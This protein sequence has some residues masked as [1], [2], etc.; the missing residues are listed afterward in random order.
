MSSEPDTDEAD[1]PCPTCER[2]FTSQKG[3]RLHHAKSHGEILRDHRDCE[4]CG[5]RFEVPTGNLRQTYCS[6]ACV[7]ADNLPSGEEHPRYAT[8]IVPCEHCAANIERQ[9]NELERSENQF[10]SRECVHAWQSEHQRGENNPQ[11]QRETVECAECGSSLA[12]VPSE[13]RVKKNHFCSKDCCYAYRRESPV[14]YGK[15]WDQQKRR[16]VRERDGW[17]CQACGMTQE[18]H[19]DRHGAKLEVHHIRPAKEFSDPE[20]RNNPGNLVTLCSGCHP[21][22]EGIPVRPEVIA[23]A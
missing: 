17:Q 5:E 2:K 8:V 18:K 13:K 12:V 19:Q 20:K 22:W 21:K 1:V 16:A 15:G 9:P 7:A 23:D 3:V 14:Q 4:R 6:P 11:Y 10:C